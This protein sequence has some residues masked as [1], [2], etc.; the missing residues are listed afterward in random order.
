MCSVESGEKTDYTDLSPATPSTNF[1]SVTYPQQEFNNNFNVPNQPNSSSG[2]SNVPVD[3]SSE[4][5][6]SNF[7]ASYPYS[8]NEQS[9]E[10]HRRST[11]NLQDIFLAP[12]SQYEVIKDSSKYNETTPLTLSYMTQQDMSSQFAYLPSKLPPQSRDHANYQHQHSASSQ[13]MQQQQQPQQQQQSSQQLKPKSPKNLNITPI[14]RQSLGTNIS[15]IIQ[16]LS[17][18]ESG[19]LYPDGR[20]SHSQNSSGGIAASGSSSGSGAGSS[21]LRDVECIQVKL[22][23]GNGSSNDET[24]ASDLGDRQRL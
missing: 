12:D 9:Q 24:D 14:K 11:K 23:E 5:N 17:G 4:P 16:N 19:L 7:I 2:H 1:P 22:E 20:L 18:S 13:H 15:S 3:F 21:G 6:S 10:A 8:S